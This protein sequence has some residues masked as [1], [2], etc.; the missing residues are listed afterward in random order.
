MTIDNDELNSYTQK[1]RIKI[2]FVKPSQRIRYT[3]RL[4]SAKS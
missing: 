3:D 1:L 2:E 4:S